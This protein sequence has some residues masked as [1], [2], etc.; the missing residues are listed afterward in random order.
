MMA[1]AMVYMYCFAAAGTGIHSSVM[2][3]CGPSQTEGP[4][5]VATLGFVL[6]VLVVVVSAVLQLD[7]VG[8]FSPSQRL[9]AASS[10]TP[11]GARPVYETADIP[12]EN[13]GNL[14]HVNEMLSP[15]SRWHA[16]SSC[17]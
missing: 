16:T 17:A 14:S 8:V 3:M 11:G 15:A 9:L 10:A 1:G 5:V 4:P 13:G 6:V 7:R 2:S 12:A